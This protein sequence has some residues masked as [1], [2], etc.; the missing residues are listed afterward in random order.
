MRGPA[1]FVEHLSS[2]LYHPR[3]DAHSNAL[4]LGVLADLC[5]QCRPF[6]KR[7]RR[8]EVVAKLNH[9]V[10]VGFQNWNIDL[11][12]GPPAG[13][14]EPPGDDLLITEATPS[15]VEIAIEAKG[16][17]TEH[18]KARRNRLRDLHAFHSH[19]HQYNPKTIAVGLL[20]VNVAPYY[21]SPTRA[22]DNVTAHRNIEKLA[23]A[24]VDLFRNLP[25]RNHA[26]DGPGMEAL[27]VIVVRHDNLLKNTALPAGAPSH[28]PTRLIEKPPA[29]QPG[30]PLH[31]ATML[32]RLCS[33]YTERFA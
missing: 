24:T 10:T 25:L 17:M 4:C 9:T 2:A 13:P 12:I 23:A 22:A 1:D 21:W 14:V 18:G 5:N 8:G 19:A 3:S 32:R 31:Y 29:P 11:A 26:S 33:A 27:S 7:A 28:E 20:V 16:I 30:D 15:V 6:A